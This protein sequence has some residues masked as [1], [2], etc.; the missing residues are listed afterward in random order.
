MGVTPC[1][2]AAVHALQ[3]S[4]IED[5]RGLRIIALAFTLAVEGPHPIAVAWALDE[6]GVKH[7][8]AVRSAEA[9]VEAAY[10][11]LL[12][13]LLRRGLRATGPL[14]V[15]ADGCARLAGRL[16]AALGEVVCADQVRATTG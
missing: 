13:D 12:S 5:L 4:P 15:D 14:L 1:L 10:L 8:L 16:R 2:H 3:G 9:G 11:T 7:W 6:D